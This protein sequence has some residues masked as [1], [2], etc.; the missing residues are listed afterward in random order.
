VPVAEAERPP[1]IVRSSR[2]GLVVSFPNGG[3]PVRLHV[4]AVEEPDQPDES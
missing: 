3:K 4:P 2:G 1:T